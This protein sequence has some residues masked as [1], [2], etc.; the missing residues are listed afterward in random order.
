MPGPRRPPTAEPRVTVV[1]DDNASSSK[2]SSA[3][4]S[5]TITPA[6][7]FPDINNRD[8]WETP[9]YNFQPTTPAQEQKWDGPGT[10]VVLANDFEQIHRVRFTV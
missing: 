8:K 4:S 5:A 10:A 7:E 3:P 9:E 1:S 6:S 2:E